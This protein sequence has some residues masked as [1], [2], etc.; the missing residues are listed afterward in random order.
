MI[1]SYTNKFLGYCLSL[2]D[3]GF[4]P[5]CLQL[6]RPLIA[7]ELGIIDISVSLS[8]MVYWFFGVLLVRVCD[9]NKFLDKFTHIYAH[10]TLSHTSG[11]RSGTPY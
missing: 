11:L 3:D 4:T 9:V 2:N 7:V 8:T 6:C 1:F 10:P 5:I